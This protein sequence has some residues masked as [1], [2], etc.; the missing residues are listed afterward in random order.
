MD[1]TLRWILY[2]II[3]VVS[4]LC[5]AYISQRVSIKRVAK[6][7]QMLLRL[8]LERMSKT[9]HRKGFATTIE[10]NQFESIYVIYHSLGKNGVMDVTRKQFMELPDEK[11]SDTPGNV[12]HKK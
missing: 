11:R 1:E 5:T 10:K 2:A 4:N 12:Y 8:E 7:V 9:A 3:V 6:G